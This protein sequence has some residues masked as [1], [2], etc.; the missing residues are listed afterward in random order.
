MVVL[1]ALSL[2]WTLSPAQDGQPAPTIEPATPRTNVFAGKDADTPSEVDYPLVVKTP[3][4]FKGRL[5][6]RFAIGNATVQAQDV[7]VAVAPDQAV[8][9]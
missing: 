5:A 8:R 9:V 3:R 2:T 6:W 1:V 7:P 4:A